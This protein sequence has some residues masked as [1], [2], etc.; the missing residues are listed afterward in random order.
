MDV[1]PEVDRNSLLPNLM[2]D[3]IDDEEDDDDDDVDYKPVL[4]DQFKYKEPRIGDN[5]QVDPHNIPQV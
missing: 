1:K 3:V 2:N 4:L 5:Y